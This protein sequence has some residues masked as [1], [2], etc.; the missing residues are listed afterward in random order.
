MKILNKAKCLFLIVIFATISTFN[1]YGQYLPDITLS[2]DCECGNGIVNIKLKYT[3]DGT[4]FAYVQR[5][6]DVETDWVIVPSKYNEYHSLGFESWSCGVHAKQ[7]CETCKN[8]FPQGHD[9]K[10]RLFWQDGDTKY[11]SNEVSYSTKLVAPTNLN[12]S[13][14]PSGVSLQWNDCSGETG[15]D[16]ERTRTG[17]GTK[18]TFSFGANVTNYIDNTVTCGYTYTYRVIAKKC[19]FAYPGASKTI[20]IPIFDKKPF[21]DSLSSDCNRNITLYWNKANSN[22]KSYKI[23][24]KGSNY[25]STTDSEDYD[26]FGGYDQFSTN[27]CG[28]YSFQVIERAGYNCVSE[29]SVPLSVVAK[30]DVAGSLVLNQPP[31][32]RRLYFVRQMPLVF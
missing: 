32:N 1:I 28:T 20:K 8:Y 30:Y 26:D 2:E 17:D 9:F 22:A 23:N 6:M 24:W 11:Y 4:K 27:N 15:Y 25:G 21:L 31:V 10:I 3:P 12:A 5:I 16:I 18:K 14:T 7:A 19:N 29:A 13:L